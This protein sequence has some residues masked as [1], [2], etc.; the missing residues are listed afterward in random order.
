[1]IDG[2]YL[3]KSTKHNQYRPHMEGINIPMIS[4]EKQTSKGDFSQLATDLGDEMKHHS[5]HN[6]Q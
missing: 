3:A 1:M 2:T 6:V 4:S 5:I